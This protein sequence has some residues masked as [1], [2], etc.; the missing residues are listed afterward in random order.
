[1]AVEEAEDA[2]PVAAGVAEVPA[3]AEVSAAAEDVAKR[4][5]E[6]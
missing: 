6:T 1:V 5:I 2:A 4:R 3:A